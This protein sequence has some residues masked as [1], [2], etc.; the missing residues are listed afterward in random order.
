[1]AD[2]GDI[3]REEVGYGPLRGYLG[4]LLRRAAGR[5][6]GDFAET[7]GEDIS[8]AEFALLTLVVENP[9][10]TQVRLAAA[11]GL[12]KSTLSPALARLTR[13]GLLKRERL[14]RDGRLQ[15]LRLAPGKEAAYRALRDRVAAHEARMAAVLSP[16]DHAQLLRLLR[17]V[18]GYPVDG[19]EA[20]ERPARVDVPSAP[21]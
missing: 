17:I 15:A 21:P 12:D 20:Q 2:G 4:H 6:L 3:G 8:S 16:E 13:R 14:A 5:V 7:L 18:V 10:I 11:L 19:A 9:G 1:M